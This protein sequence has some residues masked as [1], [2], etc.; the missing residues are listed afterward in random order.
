ML[1]LKFRDNDYDLIDDDND[2]VDG[3]KNMDNSNESV[4]I[5]VKLLQI[6]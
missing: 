3:F 1:F 5:S 2:D 4:A 6:K